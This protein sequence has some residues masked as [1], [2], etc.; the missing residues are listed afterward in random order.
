MT[1]AQVEDVVAAQRGDPLAYARLVDATRNL[2]C[3]L[4]L[5]V[6]RDVDTSEDVAQDVYIAAWHRLATLREPA[7]FLPWLKQLTRRHALN[8]TRGERRS[9]E[10]HR[11]AGREPQAVARD[12]STL[13][14]RAEAERVVQ[15]CI[16]ELPD[17]SRELMVLYYREGSSLTQ[18]AALLE[19]SEDAVKKRLERVRGRLSAAVRERFAEAARR[20]A[21]TAALTM[22]VSAAL[23]ASTPGT[24]A[25]TS[26][27]GA[28]AGSTLAAWFAPVIGAVGGL[29]GVWLSFAVNARS[30]RDGRARRGLWR[31]SLTSGALVIAWLASFAWLLAHTGDPVALALP[32]FALIGAHGGLYG[33]W[34]PRLI[35]DD[36]TARRRYLYFMLAFAGGA[37]V[38]TL[39]L[40]YALGK[41]AG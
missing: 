19:L 37:T 15:A 18:V 5:S 1:A 20:T 22:A 7:S 27:V 4:A 29:G 32:Y 23:V 10:H 40:L 3:A 12:A 9:Q 26:I 17:D 14:E 33:A 6:V 11:A 30:L 35:S 36:S 8:F 25:A 34:L 39:T 13:L 38:G 31:L 2:V 28:K 41:H 21:P 24:A 16:D